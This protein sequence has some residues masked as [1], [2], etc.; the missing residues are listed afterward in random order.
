MS[1]TLRGTAEALKLQNDYQ[2]E[3]LRVSMAYDRLVDEEVERWLAGNRTVSDSDFLPEM[4][5]HNKRVIDINKRREKH[6]AA[7]KERLLASFRIVKLQQQ[8]MS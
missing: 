4:K 2:M 6:L 1:A 8:S 5:M 3:K 7:L